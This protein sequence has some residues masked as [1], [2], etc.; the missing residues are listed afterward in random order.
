MGQI[1]RRTAAAVASLALAASA[2]AITAPPAAAATPQCSTVFASY[3]T[4]RKGSTGTKARSMECLL[5]RAGYSTT[6]N[7]SFSAHDA[8]QLA[9]FRGSIGLNKLTF[10]GRRAWSALLSRGS[11]PTLTPGSRGA[12]VL[13]LQ[14]SL[15]SAGFKVPNTGSYAAGT[16]AAVKAAQRARH[17]SVTGKATAAL[18][19]ALQHGRISAPAVAAPKK[20]ASSTSK[21]LKALAF[22]KKQIGDRYRYGASGPNAWDCSGLTQGAWKAAG[23]K[24]PHSAGA[25]FRRGKKISKS[26]LRKG[27]LVFF[28]RGISHV[29]IYAG[30][31]KVIHA[32]RP[33]AP[34]GYI[35]MK[36][37]PYQGA[38]RPS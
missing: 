29:A 20:P 38:R 8:Q 10:G 5:A 18:W 7:G 3:P 2:A 1:T 35:K 14:T 33:G 28:Y 21:G 22:A 15:R 12:A 31:G 6:V 25:Q 9:A 19:H 27:D 36:Y 32:S 30:N 13:R 17:L 11:A 4:I 24:L 26:Q 37:M 23:V 16:V 34:V